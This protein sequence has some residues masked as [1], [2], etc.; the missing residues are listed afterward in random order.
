MLLNAVF[1]GRLGQVFMEKNTGKDLRSG[2]LFVD[3]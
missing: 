2:V 1:L 3:L